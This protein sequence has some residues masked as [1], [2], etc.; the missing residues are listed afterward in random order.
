MPGRVGNHIHINILVHLLYIIKICERVRYKAENF[1]H[2]NNV[3]IKNGKII[4][5]NSRTDIYTHF[6]W[7][8][9]NSISAKSNLCVPHFHTYSYNR[10][11]GTESV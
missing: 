10:N 11:C 3:Q 1:S 8:T 9:K 7:D 4:Y 2:S 6:C 5:V